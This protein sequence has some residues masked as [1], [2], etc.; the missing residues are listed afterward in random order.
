MGRKSMDYFLYEPVEGSLPPENE[1]VEVTLTDS[2]TLEEFT[3]RVIIGSK[4]EE[5]GTS[6]MVWFFSAKGEKEK[7]PRA[8]KIIERMVEEEPDV[9]ALPR[10]RLSLGER[11]G[12]MLE[13]LLREREAKKEGK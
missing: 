13:D 6:D 10:R 9:K 7:Q 2:A 8:L 1:E 4:A 12:R 11:K 3:A 5:E